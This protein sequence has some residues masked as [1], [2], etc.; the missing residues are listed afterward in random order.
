M[1]AKWKCR[2]Q[3]RKVE[4]GRSPSHNP[5]RSRAP[6][7]S[8]ADAKSMV[9]R[10]TSESSGELVRV[11]TCSKEDQCGGVSLTGDLSIIRRTSLP[12]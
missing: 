4:V 12:T 3:R 5:G 7:Q 2:T 10:R 6:Q 8:R 1:N 9:G 11:V